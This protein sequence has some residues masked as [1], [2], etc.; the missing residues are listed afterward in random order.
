MQRRAMTSPERAVACMRRMACGANLAVLLQAA[1]A[2]RE[3]CKEG[4]KQAREQPAPERGV[5]G[6]DLGKALG[7]DSGRRAGGPKAW[8]AGRTLP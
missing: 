2:G 1:E 8:S 6:D 7:Q 5:P 3:G 4:S